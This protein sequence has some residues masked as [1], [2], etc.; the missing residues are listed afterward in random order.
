VNSIPVEVDGISFTITIFEETTGE[1]IFSR[2][3]NSIRVVSGHTPEEAEANTTSSAQSKR[4]G[5]LCSLAGSLV[6]SPITHPH[7]SRW[8]KSKLQVC[9]DEGDCK[10]SACG[11]RCCHGSEICDLGNCKTLGA[12]GVEY[13]SS[14]EKLQERAL[15]ADSPSSSMRREGSV[16]KI[17]GPDCLDH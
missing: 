2:G 8:A 9:N 11:F 16:T 7:S 6:S 1:T 10:K 14:S 17:E 15:M 13:M 3:S 4:P 12:F 5:I